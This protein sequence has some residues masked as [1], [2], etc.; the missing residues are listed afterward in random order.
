M[1]GKEVEDKLDSNLS[2]SQRRL[3][4]DSELQ[5]VVNGM[6]NSGSFY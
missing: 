6:E 3:S 5:H 2:L 1:K 4:V